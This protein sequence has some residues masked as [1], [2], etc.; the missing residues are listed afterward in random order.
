MSVAKDLF[1]ESRN[2]TQ[3]TLKA[4]LNEPFY[5]IAI[6]YQNETVKILIDDNPTQIVNI[7]NIPD[8]GFFIASLENILGMDESEE[9]VDQKSK[10]NLYEQNLDICS[11]VWYHGKILLI[12]KE[13]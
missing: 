4:L 12:R 11:T 8:I 9:R 13:I 7:D 2:F 1:E 6:F 10:I 3:S 5:S